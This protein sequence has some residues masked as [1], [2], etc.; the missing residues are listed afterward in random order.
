MKTPLRALQ[1][2]LLILAVGCNKESPKDN[3][4]STNAGAQSSALSSREISGEV[5]I[6]KPNGETVKLSLVTVQLLESEKVGEITN[7]IAAI[8]SLER[9]FSDAERISRE[10][11][12]RAK[13]I[14]AKI[15]AIEKPVESLIAQM[16]QI[17][18]ETRSAP[19]FTPADP[20]DP[21]GAV[22]KRM[23][24]IN[25]SRVQLVKIHAEAKAILEANEGRLNELKK[26]LLETVILPDTK[27]MK[28]GKSAGTVYLKLWE[29]RK[30]LQQ[31]EANL[32]GVASITT[33]ADG[34]FRL[35]CAGHKSGFLFTQTTRSF[36]KNAEHFTWLLPLPAKSEEKLLLSNHNCV[37][38]PETGATSVKPTSSE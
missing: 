16:E 3:A 8:K 14:D 28:D 25:K 23:E 29:Q 9:E 27:I 24:K 1:V 13:V 17:R 5:F 33:D 21:F 32:I 30:V 19:E 31:I 22:N 38:G 2:L 20:L 7:A 10:L 11:T 34:R 4:S 15:K 26:E 37:R 18:A 12:E 36:E 35:N 6:V